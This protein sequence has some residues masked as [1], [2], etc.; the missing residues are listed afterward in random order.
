ME[1]GSR[2]PID[3]VPYRIQPAGGVVWV[4][5]FDDQELLAIDASDGTVL[6]S[7]PVGR[8][9]GIAVTA[10][11]IYVADYSGRLVEIDPEEPRVVATH[12][13]GPN[14]TDVA[15]LDGRLLVWGLRSRPLELL[16]AATGEIL[17][18][19]GGVTAVA[20]LDGQP[21][22]AVQGA[23]IIRLDPSTL[24]GTGS[25]PLGDVGT[26]QLVAAPDRL[27]A[28]V[29]ANGDTYIYAVAVRP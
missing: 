16:D 10:E 6:S 5:D 17:A 14:A 1:I 29:S 19:A 12:E 21:W 15:V 22:A 8:A 23:E 26:D 20:V 27:W 3:A 25:I 18:T 9:T 28:Y 24:A 7:V 4:T 13:I 2:S 11:A